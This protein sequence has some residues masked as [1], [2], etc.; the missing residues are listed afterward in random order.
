MIP[1]QPIGMQHQAH[2]M[3]LQPM[4]PM[5]PMGMQPMQPMGMQPM[6]PMGMQPMQPMG[7]QPMQPMGMQPMQPG[8]APGGVALPPLVMAPGENLQR[9][10]THHIQENQ[11]NMPGGDEDVPDVPPN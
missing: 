3:Q 9:Q 10:G 5:Q 11:A 4:Q 7:M 8:M 1:M 6:Q 2:G